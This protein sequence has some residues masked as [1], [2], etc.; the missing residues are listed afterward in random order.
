[1]WI[2]CLDARFWIKWDDFRPSVWLPFQVAILWTSKGQ[3]VRPYVCILNDTYLEH[4]RTINI[5]QFRIYVL[6][7]GTMSHEGLGWSRYVHVTYLRGNHPKQMRDT[8]V[9]YR[10]SWFKIGYLPSRS[11]IYLLNMWIL[12][13]YIYVYIYIPKWNYQRI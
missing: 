11:L 4:V 9:T 7:V 13:I 6:V 10:Q 2:G 5:P 8:P 1:M 3:W 12:P